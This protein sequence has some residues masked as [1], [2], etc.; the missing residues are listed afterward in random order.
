MLGIA[1]FALLFLV[2]IGISLFLKALPIMQE[3]NIWVLLTSGNWRPF[4]GEFRIS[5]LYLK[6]RLC[7]FTGHCNCPAT[8]TAYQYL[9]EYLCIKESPQVFPAFY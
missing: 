5:S 2:V 4:K 9:S 6:Y 7:I 3:K 1:I 8:F